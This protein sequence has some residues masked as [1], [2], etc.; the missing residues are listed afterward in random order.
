MIN[1]SSTWTVT[2]IQAFSVFGS[3]TGS[4]IFEVKHSTGTNTIGGAVWTSIGVIELATATVKSAWSAVS[5]PVSM[6]TEF[7]GLFVNQVPTSGTMP[8]GAGVT[9]KYWRDDD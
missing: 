1:V 3:T 8:V 2:G 9:M 5:V 7:I 6:D 4:I